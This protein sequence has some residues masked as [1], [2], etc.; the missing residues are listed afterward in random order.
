MVITVL[1]KELKINLQKA[2]RA[3]LI[4][5]EK[6]GDETAEE[7][8]KQCDDVFFE[9]EEELNQILKTYAALIKP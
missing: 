6:D 2:Y 9:G 5:E 1:S 7:I 8:I 3:Y 4:S